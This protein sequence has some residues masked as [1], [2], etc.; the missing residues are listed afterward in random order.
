VIA[1]VGEVVAVGRQ[2][3]RK[4]WMG[5]S[6]EEGRGCGGEQAEGAPEEATVRAKLRCAQPGRP[7]VLQ[8]CISTWPRSGRVALILACHQVAWNFFLSSGCTIYW[9]WSNCSSLYIYLRGRVTDMFL[10]WLSPP[11]F[12]CCYLDFLCYIYLFILLKIKFITYFIIVYFI[13]K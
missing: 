8:R 7:H 4:L 3:S 5:R 10:S 6:A 13:T 11:F 9:V 1:R 12:Y 2:R